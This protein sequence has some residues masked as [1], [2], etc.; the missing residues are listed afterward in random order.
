M[1]RIQIEINGILIR[2][3]IIQIDICIKIIN[4]LKYRWNNIRVRN[5]KYNWIT[6]RKAYIIYEF[7]CWYSALIIH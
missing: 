4:K 2:K 1:L 5:I 6:K 3:F 7:I